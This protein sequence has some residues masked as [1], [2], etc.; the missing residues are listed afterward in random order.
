MSNEHLILCGGARLSSQKKAWKE[1]KKVELRTG[2]GGNINLRIG[3]LTKRLTANLSS[4]AQDLLEIATYVYCA[5]QATCRGGTKRIDY[6]EAWYRTFRFEIPVTNPDFWS[7]D[8]IQSDLTECLSDLSGDNFEFAF[9]R[10]TA[11]PPEYFDFGAGDDSD[12]EEV[13][14]FS[15]GLD[16]F[17]GAIDEILNRGR[18]V[19]LVSHRSNPKIAPRQQQLV[20]DLTSKVAKPSKAPVHV[21]VLV[22]KHEKELN[23]EY[24]QR[25]RSFLYT[26]IASIVADL[27][28]LKRIRFYENGVTSMNLPISQQIVSTR[29][30]RS[31]HPRFLAGACSLLSRIF[32]GGFGIENRFFWKT[33]TDVLK[34]IKDAGHA[35]LCATTVSCAHT[36]TMR[37]DEP[38]CGKCSQCVDR[39]LAALAAGYSEQEDPPS[40]YRFKLFTDELKDGLD[41]ILVES[42]VEVVN[43]IQKCDSATRFCSEFGEI[44][45]VVNLIPG[46]ADDAAEAIYGL[47]TRHAKQI[48]DAL[49]EQGRQAFTQLRL[50][51][52]PGTCLL[53]MLGA[54]LRR[55]HSD[56]HPPT[57]PETAAESVGSNGLVV[58][59]STFSV[60]WSGIG[61]IEI[62][63]K[64]EFWFLQFLAA[65]PGKYHP[66]T[67]IAE[68]LGGDE[69]DDLAPVKSRL[70]AVL[71]ERGLD[72]LAA[73]IKTQKG[74]YG[75]I[76][77][78]ASEM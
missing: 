54:G 77:T 74:H 58:D 69:L 9:S 10:R 48:G 44:S 67:D 72:G 73:L 41:K 14:L 66:V 7:S 51:E 43:R 31:T 27:F 32:S 6:G 26:S 61:P 55:D 30:T 64:K 68:K 13:M 8:E 15:G 50:G 42:Y 57:A 76:L 18:K 16:S 22:N 23:K 39:R 65:A 37:T 49:D 11:T 52:L 33:K 53:S 1:A 36:W 60:S 20:D 25:T 29:A 34:D 4:L 3:D 5:D 63:N 62:G 24:T 75:L 28:G 40:Q 78:G 12:V 46:L 59:Q 21:P 38:H 70:V 19:A 71:K 47:Y 2:D 45:R 17:G 56:K 35:S